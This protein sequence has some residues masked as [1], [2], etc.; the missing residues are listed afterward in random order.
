[1][2]KKITLIFLEALKHFP[3]QFV[4]IF[5]VLLLLFF[6][7]SKLDPFIYIK[8]QTLLYPSNQF[9]LSSNKQF[10]SEDDESVETELHGGGGGNY[11]QLLLF[12]YASNLIEKRDLIS[13]SR[14]EYRA[15]NI[16]L[17]ET[18]RA[19]TTCRLGINKSL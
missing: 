14:R 10:Q 5:I 3:I 4:N 8:A 11:W 7:E 17:P 9:S 19:V 6:Y 13:R 2:Q 12:F 15:D 16:G 18:E 1:M